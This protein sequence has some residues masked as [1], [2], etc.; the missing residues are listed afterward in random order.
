MPA[1]DQTMPPTRERL[2][3]ALTSQLRSTPLSRITVSGLAEEAGITRQAFYYHFADVRDLAAWVFRTDVANGILAHASYGQWADGLLELLVY[4]RD[5]A[6]EADAV[7][8]SLSHREL[9]SFFFHALRPMMDAI[10][11]ELEEGLR[12]DGEDRSFIIDHYTLS[13]LGHFMHWLATGMRDDPAALVDRMETL[14]RGSV[15]ASLERF[16]RRR[17]APAPPSSTQS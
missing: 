3:A 10:V 8:R 9:E 14:M 11:G 15:R 7:V 1:P 2:R 12:V 17:G 6:A 5:H 13:V 4:V 16:D